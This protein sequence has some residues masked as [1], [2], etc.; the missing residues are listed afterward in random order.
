MNKNIVIIHYNTPYLTEC[1]VR[2]INLFVK[3]AKIYIFD[4]SD[5]SPFVAKFDNV[6]I[7][8]NTKGQIIDFNKWLENYPD[9]TKTSAGRNGYGSAKHAYSVQKCI[10]MLDDNFVLLDSDILLKK[11]I[12]EFFNDI[13]IFVGAT[14]IWKARTG[15]AKTPRE[16]AIPYICFINV[17][18]CKRLGIKYFDDK[19]IYGLTQN[20][21]NYDTGASFFEDIKKNK[22]LW[23]KIALPNF[24]VHYKAGS[25]VE[26][27]KLHD[28]Y[29]PISFN[30][31]LEK[32]KNLWY[33]PEPL[34]GKKVVYTCIT[35]GYDDL[36]P[37]KYVNKD[38]DYVC[39]TDNLE[40]KS[41]VWQIRPLPAECEELSQVKKQRYVKINPHKV[42]S[43]YDISI[44]VDGCVSLNDNLNEF[45]FDILTDNI[46]I[47]V[48]KHPMRNC[49]YKEAKAVLS[50]GRDKKEIVNPQIERY[51]KEG[52]PA[53][54][55]LLQSN[56]L[57]RKHNEEDCIRLMEAWFNEL[58]DNSHRDQL[59]FNY[60]L[61][62]NNDI[63]IKYLDKY[64]YKSKW[65][66]WNGLH[67]K[68]KPQ[69]KKRAKITPQKPINHKLL[70]ELKMKIA[71]SRMLRTQD[72]GL[73]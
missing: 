46:S 20:G 36:K 13:Y 70:E 7:L 61:W 28:N 27:A 37:P 3:K 49:I 1:L 2:S 54:Y 62:K 50:M 32:N 4:N 18:K 68:N 9:K 17:K 6:T 67:T 26:D 38:F 31:W 22:L 72:T 45:L 58:K 14:E 23:K 55:G 41:D 53:E 51:K 25:W 71:K 15:I 56:I 16:R 8:D 39:F 44:W 43:E 42:L 19:R 33:K 60:V 12:S 29:R 65:F 69:I 10:E 64:I 59:S 47:Y 34:K 40:M 66:N 5:E 21:D 11:D 30:A 48:P 24:I 35:G 63:K 73:Y 52:F 57:V